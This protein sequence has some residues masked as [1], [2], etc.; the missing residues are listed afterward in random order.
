MAQRATDV[1]FEGDPAE[2]FSNSVRILRRD[3][4]DYRDE[5]T[6]AVSTPLTRRA[7]IHELRMT[8]R[9]AARRRLAVVGTLLGA[10]LTLLVLSGTGVTPWWSVAIP[11]GLLVAFLAVARF[12][13]VAMH[14]SLDARA[15]AV[16]EGFLEDEE[17]V[18]IDLGVLERTEGIEIS[19]DLS[20]PT[21]T[22]MLW[23]PIPVTPATYV[24]QPLLPRTVRTIDL[25]APVVAE[26]P[27][28]PT[29]DNPA[30][31][32]V[33][34]DELTLAENITEFR[35][36]RSG[37]RRPVCDRPLGAARLVDA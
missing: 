8:A 13:V 7:E 26:A 11:S 25:S 23:D 10:A 4:E 1:E 36:G 20:M 37:S 12:S 2:R 30:H 27:L 17:T 33:E 9:Q 34:S 18:A 24:S 35:P 16:D 5:D 28:V 3:V 19:V 31:D 22:G 29:A 32:V 6:A 14:R 21:T 15:A